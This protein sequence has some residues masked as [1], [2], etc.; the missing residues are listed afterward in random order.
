VI[1]F[2]I[3]RLLAALVLIFVISIIAYMLLYF[4]SE[5]V[6]RA[7]LGDA[8]TAEQIA[9]KEQELGLDRPL[10]ERYLGWLTAAMTGDFGA[11]WFGSESVADAIARRLPVT[12][13][14]VG[15][16][17]LLTAVLSFV[18]GTI[19]ALRRGWVDRA[20]QGVSVVTDAIP[21]YVIAIILV[22]IFAIQLQLFPPVSIIGPGAGVDAWVVS[23]TLPIAALTINA[24][25][26]A[27]QQIRSA[28][29]KQ[30]EMDYVRTLRS[31][32]LGEGE[33]IGAHVLRSA[34]PP[35]L[36][37]LSLQFVGMLSGAVVIEQVFALP[38]IG[39][40]AISA[41]VRGDVPVV[42]GVVLYTV[43]IVMIVNF[44][45]DLANGWLNPKV[46]VS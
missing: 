4:S 16:S 12:L 37:L 22:A 34:A 18:L 3:R 9:L 26:G 21:S 20:I 14:L 29:S 32:G 17:M 10:L 33:V 44:L 35:T 42:M 6:A 36:T 8:A 13:T 31:R 41:T 38:G 15:V 28:V 45:V 43:I 27:T 5:N 39:P 19:A 30:L 23:L 46:R 1:A 11:T 40:F 2:I 24:F 7:I 25:V